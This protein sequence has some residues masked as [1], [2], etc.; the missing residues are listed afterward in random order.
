MKS[1][2]MIEKRFEE[3][4][5]MM[6]NIETTKNRTSHGVT[7]DQVMYQEWGTNV[8]SLFQRIFKSDAIHIEAFKSNYDAFNGLAHEFDNCKGIFKAA[9]SDYEGGYL[10][11]VDSLISAEI[12]DD[13]IE[14]ANYLFSKDYK[15]A[16]CIV[17]RVALETSLKKLCDRNSILHGKL[18]K[19]NAD[20]CKAGVYN[21]GMQK[22]ITAWADRGN[23]AA[24]G[25]WDEYT[26]DDVQDMLKGIARFIAE[27]L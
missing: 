7:V 17:G 23:K 9:K 4:H 18:D 3:L 22:Q 20:L 24:H 27:M 26:K 13:V 10:F 5:T 2:Q 21:I 14:Q 1:N 15:D 8:L 12:L 19:M 16:A 11:T 6:N 25:L